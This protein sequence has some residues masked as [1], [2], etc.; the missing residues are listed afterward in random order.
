ENWPA[1]ERLRVHATAIHWSGTDLK[2]L[3]VLNLSTWVDKVVSNGVTSFL[4]DLA[5]RPDSYP[6]LETI[7]LEECPEWDILVLILERRNL[8]TNSGA[9]QISSVTFP[10]P[11]PYHLAVVIRG[12]LA[13]RWTARPSNRE[14]SWLGMQKLF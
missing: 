13:G 14:L 1:L 2:Y 8:M 12:L 11:P 4:R 7:H 3:R 9:R 10:F 5:C 6:S